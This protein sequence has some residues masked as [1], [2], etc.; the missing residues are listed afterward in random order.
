MQ[1]VSLLYIS[2]FRLFVSFVFQLRLKFYHLCVYIK[3][4]SSPA[5]PQQADPQGRDIAIRP[6]LEHCENTHM[7]IWL[8]IVY[9][10]KGLLMVS[11][12]GIGRDR[13]LTGHVQVLF[14]TQ[15]TLSKLDKHQVLTY[16]DKEMPM[17]TGSK[18]W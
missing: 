6:F 9:A 15:S 7:T 3:L 12:K 18:S 17:K 8:G 10:Y 5:S 11:G 2:R 1:P 16:V 4:S 14:G 13:K